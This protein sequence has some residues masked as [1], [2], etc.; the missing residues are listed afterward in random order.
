[1]KKKSDACSGVHVGEEFMGKIRSHI[2]IKLFKTHCISTTM[3]G[4]KMIFALII[5]LDPIM[6]GLIPF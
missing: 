4:I 1:M 5:I 2:M 3:N 6:K